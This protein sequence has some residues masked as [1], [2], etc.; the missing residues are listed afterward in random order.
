MSRGGETSGRSEFEIY[1]A[2]FMNYRSFQWAA[3]SELVSISISCANVL[4]S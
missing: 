4:I 2:H 3:K 1:L